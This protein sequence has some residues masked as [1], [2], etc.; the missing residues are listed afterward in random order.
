M[1][2]YLR[3]RTK[4]Y[5]STKT[6]IEAAWLQFLWKPNYSK[7]EICWLLRAFWISTL[8]KRKVRGTWVKCSI[9]YAA[10]NRLG[11]FLR[12]QMR[13]R[14]WRRILKN[15]NECKRK[16]KSWARLNPRY[17]SCSLP[18]SNWTNEK[19]SCPHICR[20]N[21]PNTKKQSH[22]YVKA[23]W[24]FKKWRVKPLNWRMRYLPYH[25]VAANTNPNVRST[26]DKMKERDR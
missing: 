21:S 1:R 3:T 17:I 18:T 15:V 24:P 12:S 4:N 22:S 19:T 7:A 20:N 11:R 5:Q 26:K 10:Q 9:G 2:T 14:S 23:K 16:S 8:T 13:L 25:K 6:N